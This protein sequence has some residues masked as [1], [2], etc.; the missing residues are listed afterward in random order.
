MNLNYYKIGLAILLYAVAQ[1]I[2]WFQHNWQFKDPDK[3][4]TWWGWYLAAIP[5]TWLFLMATKTGVE[6]FGGQLWPNRFIGFVIGMLS[7]ILL[8]SYFFDEHL[9]PKITVQLTLCFLI[10]LVQILWK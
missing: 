6:G 5:L 7:Y 2:V 8:T 10:L 4:P 3:S 9:T 1:T